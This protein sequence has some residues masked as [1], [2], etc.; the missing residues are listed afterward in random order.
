LINES[1]VDEGF[2]FP[3]NWHFTITFCFHLIFSIMV[4][5]VVEALG[6]KPENRGFYSLWGLWEFTFI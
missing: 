4:A 3:L 2:I 1:G 5:Q 6:Y